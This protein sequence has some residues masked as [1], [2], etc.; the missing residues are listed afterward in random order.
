MK[1]RNHECAAPARRGNALVLALIIVMLVSSMGAVFLRISVAVTNRQT[2]E[3]ETLKAFYLAEA[4][5]AEAFQAVRVGRTGQLGSET[6]PA[7]HG[8]GLLWVDATQTVDEQMNSTSP[9]ST[10]AMAGSARG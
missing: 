6:A 5:L 8:D 4:G 9:F 1:P 3:V 2:A 7:V 10:A